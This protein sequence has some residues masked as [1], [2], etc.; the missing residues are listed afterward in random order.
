MLIHEA[1]SLHISI[2]KKFNTKEWKIINKKLLWK[3]KRVSFP[4]YKRQDI[5]VFRSN[6]IPFKY[7]SPDVRVATIIWEGKRIKA[8]VTYA[9]KLRTAFSH[10]GRNNAQWGPSSMRMNDDES[11]GMRE[12]FE[13]TSSSCPLFAWHRVISV[14]RLVHF[15]KIT[16]R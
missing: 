14:L 8:F 4:C 10:E 16:Y 2:L 15:D 11:F 3:R 5:D 1:N 6:V 9:L 13:W 7:C 12:S